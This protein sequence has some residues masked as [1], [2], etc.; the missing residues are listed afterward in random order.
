MTQQPWLSNY[1]TGINPKLAEVKFAH[2]PELIRAASSTYASTIAFT[3][4]MPNGMNG[5]LTYK[6]VDDLSDDF[7]V[8]LREVIGLSFG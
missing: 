4:C 8:Y 7:A 1:P 3:Q 2:L 5:S 6:Q